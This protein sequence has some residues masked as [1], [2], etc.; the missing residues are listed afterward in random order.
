MVKHLLL[1]RVARRDT[2]SSLSWGQRL[3]Q[4]LQSHALVGLA[5]LTVSLPMPPLQAAT[6]TAG[7]FGLPIPSLPIPGGSIEDVLK[8]AVS[9]QLIKT[10]GSTLTTESPISSSSE[11]LFPTVSQLPGRAFNPQAMPPNLI[12]QIRS[13]ADGSVTLLPGDYRIPVNVFCMKVSA[14]S[15]AGHRYLLAPLKGKSADIITA[16][17]ARSAG[18]LTPHSQLQVLSWNLQSGMKY[19]EL[20]P[21]LRTIVDQFLPDYKSRLSQSFYER[22]ESTWSN[23][24]GAIPGLPSMDSSL[25]R[26]GRVGQTIVTLRQTRETLMRYGNNFE[27]LSRT[28]VPTGQATTSGSSANTPWSQISP[29]VYARLMTQGTYADPGELQV[30]VVNAGSIGLQPGQWVAATSLAGTLNLAAVPVKVPLAG[31]VGDPQDASVQPLS[32][33]PKPD[34]KDE[35]ESGS[36]SLQIQEKGFS[37][38]Q[39]S[40]PLNQV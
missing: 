20:T 40:D 34:D 14:H 11:A 19:E 32:M 10:L 15:P 7:F 28:F 39:R 29:Q 25:G 16:L 12:S 5:A 36:G 26:L 1:I 30:R 9:D 23:L 33:S 38:P 22:I 13:A 17:N 21:E 31:L 18:T 3:R 35:E 24:S 37:G 6:V 27:S 2:D 4:S 8:G